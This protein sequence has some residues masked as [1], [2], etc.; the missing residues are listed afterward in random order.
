MQFVLI[1]AGTFQMGSPVEEKDRNWRN[2]PQHRVTLTQPFYLQTTPV[3]QG[4]WQSVM[5][6]NPSFLKIE[7]PSFFKKWLGGVNE[8]NPYEDHPVEGV[9]WYGAQEFLARLNRMEKTDKYRLPSEGEWEYACRAGSTTKYSFGD[10]EAMLQDY[11]W[12]AKNSKQ[13]THPVGQK[14]PNAC[15]LYDMH[16]NVWEWCLD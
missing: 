6:E 5:G 15:G 1:Q 12:Y 14:K 3:T 16:G 11:A 13:E 8:D 10:D 4:Q 9:S 7:K 2:E